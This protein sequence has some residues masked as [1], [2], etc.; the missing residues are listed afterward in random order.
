MIINIEALTS[1]YL[2]SAYM[3]V[4][5]TE[6]NQKQVQVKILSLSEELYM[7][8]EYSALIFCN[9]Y[10]QSSSEEHPKILSTKS[11]E[12]LISCSS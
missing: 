4:L 1:N 10:Y 2:Q 5:K 3:T 12:E 8:I 7:L 6:Y 9:M 11:R